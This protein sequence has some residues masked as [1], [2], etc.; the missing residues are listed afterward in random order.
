MIQMADPKG[1]TYQVSFP[2]A[3][4]NAREAY[5]MIANILHSTDFITIAA[6]V[7]RI[8][9]GLYGDGWLSFDE[10]KCFPLGCQRDRYFKVV[11]NLKYPRKANNPTKHIHLDE[12]EPKVLRWDDLEPGDA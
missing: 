4:W 8:G 5:P 11:K 10:A 1:D 2:P 6:A 7:Q 12:I 9:V 3:A